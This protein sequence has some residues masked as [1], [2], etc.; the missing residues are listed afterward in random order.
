M[1]VRK[2]GSVLTVIYLDLQL[3]AGSSHLLGDSRASLASSAVLLRIEFT[4]LRCS[5]EAGALLPRL[6]TL[7]LKIRRYLS[8][9]LSLGSPPAAVSRYPCPG[10]LGLSSDARFRLAPATARL[11][12]SLYCIGNPA[13]VSIVFFRK[14]PVLF[15][16]QLLRKIHIVAVGVF[17]PGNLFP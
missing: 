13:L 16:P 6:F 15:I 9:A 7:T 11:A 4:A 17:K 1:R 2:P 10:E 8:V 5:H 14:H 3:L 12:H